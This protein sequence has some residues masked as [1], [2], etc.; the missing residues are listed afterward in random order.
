MSSLVSSQLEA[1][2]TSADG[3]SEVDGRSLEEIKFNLK[4]KVELKPSTFENAAKAL[5]TS[6]EETFSNWLDQM[7]AQE[8]WNP[9]CPLDLQKARAIQDFKVTELQT[10]GR[11][12][13]P[14]INKILGGDPAMPEK[15]GKKKPRSPVFLFLGTSEIGEFRKRLEI[16]CKSFHGIGKDLDAVS[17]DITVIMPTS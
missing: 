17:C 3:D 7:E 4:K 14:E 5:L 8:K 15:P 1:E 11:L 13:N 16:A 2:E 9:D 6:K 10:H 12:F